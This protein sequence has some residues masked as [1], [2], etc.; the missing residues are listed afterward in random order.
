MRGEPESLA[1]ATVAARA[2]RAARN[3]R[4]HHG[5]RLGGGAAGHPVD[6]P[7]GG[8]PRLRAAAAGPRVLQSSPRR[9]TSLKVDGDP[10][11]A[12]VPRSAARSAE[13]ETCM[14][15]PSEISQHGIGTTFRTTPTPSPR[16]WIA[17]SP[18]P[19]ANPIR[20]TRIRCGEMTGCGR[21]PHPWG[22]PGRGSCTTTSHPPRLF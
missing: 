18:G 16:S 2:A 1:A 4:D 19:A 7:L 9:S 20:S 14:N 13:H 12:V 17:S 11:P 21:L 10:Y 15:A 8:Q 22:T 3:H 6:G 5:R